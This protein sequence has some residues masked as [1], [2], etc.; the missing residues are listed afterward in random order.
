MSILKKYDK[1]FQEK[2]EAGKAKGKVPRAG[3][4]DDNQV[5]RLV[6]LVNSDF[7]MSTKDTDYKL[8]Q[9]QLIK[10]C[11]ILLHKI[12][13]NNLKQDQEREILQTSLLQNC[14]ATEV[15]CK[16]SMEEVN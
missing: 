1:V 12:N 14:K 4:M 16:S 7:V 8:N 9:D 11:K 2:D 15:A 3:I 6:D 10:V 13:H 5:Y